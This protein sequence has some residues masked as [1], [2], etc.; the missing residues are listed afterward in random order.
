MEAERVGTKR[1]ETLWVK[2]KLKKETKPKNNPRNFNSQLN[3]PPVMF[4]M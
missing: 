4:C 3:H 2:T 1:A